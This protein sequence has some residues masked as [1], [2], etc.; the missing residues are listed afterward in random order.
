MEV[1]VDNGYIACIVP[2]EKLAFD[3]SNDRD[4]GFLD[5]NCCFDPTA[6][7]PSLELL[8]RKLRKP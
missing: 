2:F 4:E 7:V 8:S 6:V 5:E 1:N 3:I